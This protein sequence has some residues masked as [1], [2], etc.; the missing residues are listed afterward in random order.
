[1]K[2]KNILIGSTLSLSLLA[3]CSNEVAA[4]SEEIVSN[5]LEAGKE[6]ESYYGKATFRMY[7]EGQETEN[8]IMEEYVG[9]NDKRKIITTDLNK[10]NQKAYA[11]NDG[12]QFIT[13]DEESKKALSMD[14]EGVGLPT[15]MTQKEQFTT[16]LEQ[17]KD[18]H[19]YE[20]VGEEEMLGF[21]T[22]HLKI[23]ANSKDSLL[24]DMEIWVDK[25]TWFTL[26]TVVNSS[27]IRSE[28]VYNEVDFAP[29][30]SEDTFEVNLPEGVEISPMETEI[31]MN[32]GTIEEAKQALGQPFLLFHDDNQKVQQIEWNVIEGELNRTEVA[33]LYSNSDNIPTFTLS[34]FPTPEGQGMEIEESEWKVRGQKAEYMEEIRALSWDEEGIRYSILIEHPELSVEEIIELTETMQYETE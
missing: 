4:S 3:G 31:P 30:F 11:Y 8:L 24:G 23:T 26:K 25:K 12:K 14:I 16:L 32:T 34:I 17:M 28:V 9:G 18:T 5:V 10:N 33:I 2:F 20:V 19:T 21:D 27:G 29:E 6:I 15:S 7:T 1:M 13:Y 22:Y